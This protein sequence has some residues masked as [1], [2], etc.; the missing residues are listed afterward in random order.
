MSERRNAILLGLLLFAQL[1]VLTAQVPSEV[2]GNSLLERM[3][4][5]ALA[6]P[7]YVVHRGGELGLDVRRSLAR[8]RYL[9]RDNA[10]LERRV[11]ELESEVVR[12]HNL[13]QQVLGVSELLE[14]QPPEAY[15]AFVGEVVFVDHASWVRTLI[16]RVPGPI[17]DAS[18]PINTPVIEPDGL[19]GR[20]MTSSGRYLRA[21]LITDRASGVSAMIERTRRQGI[22]RGVGDGQLS[23]DYLP[24][25]EDVR[26]GDRILTAGVDGVY[27]RGLVLGTVT[28][29]ESG[30]T[31]FY[32][33][34]VLP[35][36]DFSS[37]D[38]TLLLVRDQIPED[39]LED[40]SVR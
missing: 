39:L 9:E 7:A 24:L 32:R 10:S 25:Q 18:I 38:Q 27:P 6:P 4:L 16:L 22:V 1:L 34:R 14:W 8:R 37:L 28:E 2:G 11:R 12:L 15:R 30:T 3:A 19:I 26:L 31:C 5:R 17:E 40:A 36:V 33:V 35:A 20:V 21:Q 29:V 13:E 23:M